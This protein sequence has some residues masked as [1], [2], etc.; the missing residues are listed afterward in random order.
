MT[1]ACSTATAFDAKI[2]SLL[3]IWNFV[4]QEIARRIAEINIIDN[5]NKGSLKSGDVEA[6]SCGDFTRFAAIQ[7]YCGRVG[8]CVIETTG[9][10]DSLSKRDSPSIK[11]ELTLL[12]GRTQREECLRFAVD[13]NCIIGTRENV[14]R[15]L[16]NQCTKWK[17]RAF[18]LALKHHP[19]IKALAFWTART[20]NCVE[21]LFA[22]RTHR[23]PDRSY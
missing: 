13:I 2:T 14:I 1:L 12:P 19:G 7:E 10:A 11:V 23:Q 16:I 22:G 8:E 4:R 18:A 6:Q 9:L 15:R 3:R 20:R 21:N 5:R 17:R